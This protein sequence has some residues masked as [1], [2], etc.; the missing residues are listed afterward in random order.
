MRTSN[1][2]IA[3]W[4]GSILFHALLFIVFFL[5]GVPQVNQRPEFVQMSWGSLTGVAQAASVTSPSRG[6]AADV[7]PSKSINVSRAA[8]TVAPPE[9]QLPDFSNEMIRVPRTEKMVSTET[10]PGLQ[11]DSRAGSVGERESAADQGI[12][13]KETRLPGGG[14]GSLP[15]PATPTAGLSSIRGSIE[16]G[17]SYSV[18]WLGG[19]TRKRLSGDLPKY[20]EGVNIEAQI[21]IQA[22]VV[23]DGS[24]K[25]LQPAQKGNTKLEEVAMREVRFWK[26]EPLSSSQPQVEQKCEIVFLFTL[27]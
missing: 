12:G 14:L 18:Q 4:I 22:V 3:G 13:V 6:V 16:Q 11:R 20:P 23:P 1:E 26:F 9:R 15:G 2:N 5:T 7:A 25:A 19:G 17:A 24:V 21:R 27:K 8:Q 10:D